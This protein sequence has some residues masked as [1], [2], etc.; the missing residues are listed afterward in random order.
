M[1]LSL[2]SST[3][4]DAAV[5]FQIN[6]SIEL[7]FNKNISSTSLND[8]PIS[9][10]DAGTGKVVPCLIT[11]NSLDAKLLKLTPSVSLR[12]N[13]QYKINIIGYSSGLGYYLRAS[14]GEYLITTLVITF[15]TG[16]NVY[17][18]D[19]TLEKEAQ[20]VSLEADLFLPTNVK[21]LGYDFTIEYVRPLNHSYDVPQNITGDNT[22]KF[23]FSKTLYTGATFDTWI[24]VDAYPILDADIYLASGETL[25]LG[26]N[27]EI[28]IP[29]Y[30]V[31]ASDNELIVTFTSELPK[32]AMVEI[33]LLD[34]ITTIDGD[35]YGGNMHYSFTTQLFPSVPATQTIR[36]EVRAVAID[37]NNDYINT[38]L[39]KNII[40]LWERMGRSLD[41]TSFSF[42]AKQYIIYATALDLIEDKDLEK[43][44]LAGSRRQLADL[45]VSF[46]SLIGKLALKTIKL[47]KQKELALETLFKGWQFRTGISSALL[48]AASE[49]NRLWYDVSSRY[50]NPAY[51]YRQLDEPAANTSINRHAKTNNPYIL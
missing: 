32:N 15:H 42:P 36:R 10:I 38:L 11:L 3:P 33:E 14:D 22:I 17:K 41:T 50:T 16:D 9:L 5:D 1:T 18:I 26:I 7:V 12:E 4:A 35:Y 28:A 44:V 34:G 24:N 23:A 6:K 49:I 13:S 51:K 39:F 43:Y 19:T 20:A 2:L 46:D 48:E 47:Q 29:N 8:S 25:N 37:F 27:T 45:N 30:E 40:W 21:A 31:T